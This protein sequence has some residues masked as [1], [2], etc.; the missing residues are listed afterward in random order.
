MNYSK[1]FPYK[2]WNE[3]IIHLDQLDTVKAEKTHDD[4]HF[5]QHELNYSYDELILQDPFI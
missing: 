3:S 4:I 5:I 1:K 2:E